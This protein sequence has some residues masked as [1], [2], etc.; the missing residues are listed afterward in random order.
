[1]LDLKSSEVSDF[2]RVMNGSRAKLEDGPLV[3]ETLK[4]HNL[5][6][7]RLESIK[8]KS[9]NMP[10]D[11]TVTKSGNLV[12]TDA[13]DKTLNVTKNKTTRHVIKQRN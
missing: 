10:E 7:Q 9:G 8:T 12:Y 13:T 5:Q 6:G 2:V 11:I 4:L 1:M 3:I